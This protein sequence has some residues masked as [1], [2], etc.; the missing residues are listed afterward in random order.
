MIKSKFFEDYMIDN[1]ATYNIPA[2][3]TIENR[4]VQEGYIPRY[5]ESD[6][7]LL[8]GPKEGYLVDYMA[9]DNDKLREH[10]VPK[11]AEKSKLLS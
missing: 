2:E 8:K 3:K 4:G 1:I 9:N 11:Y 5:N 7:F 10:Y 6:R